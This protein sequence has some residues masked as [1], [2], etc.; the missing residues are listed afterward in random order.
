MFITFYEI[1]KYFLSEYLHPTMIMFFFFS[2]STEDTTVIEVHDFYIELHYKRN[3]FFSF[4]LAG[5]NDKILNM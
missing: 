4:F 3:V 2:M 1:Q 5:Q